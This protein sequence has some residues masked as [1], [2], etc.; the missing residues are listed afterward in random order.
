MFCK[1]VY[2]SDNVAHIEIPAGTPVAMNL[3]NILRRMNQYMNGKIQMIL[4]K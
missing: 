2:I 1:I 4:K 3:M